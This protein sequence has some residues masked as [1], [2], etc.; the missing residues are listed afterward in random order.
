VNSKHQDAKK[1]ASDRLDLIGDAFDE[2]LGSQN[3]KE[4]FDSLKV[5]QSA[6]STSNT[7]SATN[8]SAIT[9]KERQ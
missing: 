7:K 6:S 5:V 8:Q 4:S 1:Q 9:E 2:I 3:I